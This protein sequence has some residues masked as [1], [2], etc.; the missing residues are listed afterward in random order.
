MTDFM[1]LAG[2]LAVLSAL[3]VAVPLVAFRA[4]ARGRAA[5]DADVFRDQLVEVERDLARGLI[6]ER[7][8]EGTRAEIARRLIAADAD[9]RHSEGIGPAPRSASRV[10]GA[11]V[12][13]GLPALG[14]GLYAALGSPG[15]PDLPFAAREDE[16]ADAMAAAGR[17]SQAAAEAEIA[18]SRPAT[19]PLS[20]EMQDYAG[21]ITQLE[22]V[23]VDRP[24][25]TRGL[26]YLADGY[27]RL[28]RYAEAWPLY[29]RIAGLDGP[30][31]TVDV[32]AAQAEAMVLATGGYVS[33]EAQQ[34]IE[35][36]LAIDPAIPVV[37][38]YDGLWRAQAGRLAEAAAI[39]RDLD[40]TAPVDAPWRP[41]LTQTLAEVERRL[42]LADA[43]GPDAG[44]RAAAA[45]MSPEQR[46]AMIEGMVANLETRIAEQGGSPEEWF[47]LM[48]AYAV[49]GRRGEARDVY[50][51]SQSAL[52]GSE[53]GFV[54]E[55]A[56]LLG[57]IDNP[58]G[59]EGEGTP[60]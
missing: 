49:M 38:Y 57:L 56:L 50:E 16:R 60:Q 23:V 54:R 48:N 14:A 41:W 27:T 21:L 43:P 34:V 3:A 22:T 31:A 24:E 33:P 8:A 53:A 37:R 47:R 29:A 2:G 17:P 1:L 39:W 55:Q 32:L 25:D 7:E 26:R 51:R 58:D 12:L 44:A 36:T 19:P 6:S 42:T 15:A 35:R 52:D 13:V 5:R 9:A 10:L 40:R 11:L 59:I 20:E 28:G 4:R 18:A 30:R 46:Q 45:E